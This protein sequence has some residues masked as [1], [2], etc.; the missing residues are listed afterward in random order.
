MQF[1]RIFAHFVTHGIFVAQLQRR[2]G[3]AAPAV[4][5]RNTAAM[6]G[7]P[8][9]DVEIAEFAATNCHSLKNWGRNFKARSVGFSWRILRARNGPL[10]GWR[11]LAGRMRGEEIVQPSALKFRSQ[12]SRSGFSPFQRP[13]IQPIGLFSSFC[14]SLLSL[15]C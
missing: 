11:F 4:G 5:P 13:R 8:S 7:F 2:P 1:R 6:V 14:C 9:I 12:L 3:S 10:R 15:S